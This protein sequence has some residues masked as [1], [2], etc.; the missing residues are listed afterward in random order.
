MVKLLSQKLVAF[1]SFRFTLVEKPP[2][3]SRLQV[4]CISSFVGLGKSFSGSSSQWAV[5]E[6]IYNA[7]V[8]SSIAL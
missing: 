7:V 4:A 5:G 3:R 2:Q 6:N 8:D 1:P